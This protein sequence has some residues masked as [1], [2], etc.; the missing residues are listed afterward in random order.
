MTTVWQLNSW[1]DSLIF[2]YLSHTPSFSSSHFFSDA[3]PKAQPLA[4]LIA[5]HSSV[6]F[7]IDKRLSFVFGDVVLAGEKKVEDL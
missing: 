6:I 3:S 7:I 4:Q 1:R 5:F 2:Y